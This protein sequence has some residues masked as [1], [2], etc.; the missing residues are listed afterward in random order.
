MTTNTTYKTSNAMV[1]PQAANY[2]VWILEAI[3]PEDYIVTMLQRFMQEIEFSAAYPKFGNVRIGSVHPFAMLLFQEVLGQNFD[4]S[5]FPS[6][7]VADN[8]ESETALTLGRDRVQFML[9]QSDVAELVGQRIVK[10]DN[11]NVGSLFISDTGL[12]RMQAAVLTNDLMAEQAFYSS[13]HTVN[14][15]IWADNRDVTNA[16]YDMVIEFL[17]FSR[18]ELHQA[19]IDIV[20][21]ISGNRTGDINMDFG[22]LLYGS[23]IE[24]HCTVRGGTMRVEIPRIYNIEHIDTS[25]PLDSAS[26]G[27]FRVKE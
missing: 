26:E 3:N 9:T 12:A 23:N 25:P 16:I 2:P 21:G 7:T 8:S 14:V 20:E 17:N 18:A 5:V 11:V 10:V 24:L 4:M 27:H 19:G 1:A 15:N 6:I 22:T 13:Q